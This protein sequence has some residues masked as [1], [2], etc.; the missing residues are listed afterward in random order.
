MVFSALVHQ[1]KEH[2]LISSN[3]SCEL[4]A[5][6]NGSQDITQSTAGLEVPSIGVDI[7]MAHRH[8]DPNADTQCFSRIGMKDIHKGSIIRG[9]TPARVH[10]FKHGASRV[11][12]WIGDSTRDEVRN[13]GV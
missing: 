11:Q 2:T 8:L 3:R 9:K 13:W 10:S 1:P 4:T 6:G 7:N 12:A 5:I